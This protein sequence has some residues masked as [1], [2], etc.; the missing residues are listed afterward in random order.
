MDSVINRKI[1]TA[2]VG[3]GRISKNH[4][5]S[6]EKHKDNMELISI[7]DTQQT[8]LSV[9]EKKYNVKGYLDLDDMLKKEDLDLIIKIADEEGV[10]DS[11]LNKFS[12]NELL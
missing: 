9:H 11:I 12:M 5:V 10:Y 8:I 6:L 1:R 3:C 4:F 7:C 2:I